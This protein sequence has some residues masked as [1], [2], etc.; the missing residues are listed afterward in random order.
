MTFP[1][2]LLPS[3]GDAV[4]YGLVPRFTRAS[5]LGYNP[6]VDTATTPEDAWG[7]SGIYPWLPGLTS[8]EILSSGAAAANDTAAGTGARTVSVT[9]LDANYNVVTMTMTLNG[10]TP[11]A[12]PAQVLRINAIRVLTA[13]SGN[14]NAADIIVR[15]A[16]AGTTRGIILTGIGVARQAPF[17]VPAGFTLA[18]R[19]IVLV[20]DS[21]AGAVGQ[22]A[23]IATYFK[24]PTGA[25]I[26]PLVLG[27][28]SGQPYAH[29]ADPPIMAFEKT[30]FSLIITK[31]TDN[32]TIVTAGWNGFLRAN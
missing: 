23:T 17:T 3:F 16:G 12:L 6:D 21:P 28:T 10:A 18:I 7:S 31:A 30:D 11:V 24:T 4:S 19:Q 29:I 15:D 8:L 22:F 27:N 14:S 25:A 9:T 1:S 32:N 2:E 13:G 5:G 20:V 26:Q